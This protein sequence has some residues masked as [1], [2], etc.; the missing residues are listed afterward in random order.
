MP[1]QFVGLVFTDIVESTAR[2]ERLGPEAADA[3]RRAHF[4][5]LRGAIDQHGGREVKNLGDGLMVAFASVTDAVAGA[6]ALQQA[7]ELAGRADGDPVRIR[8]GLSSGDVDE[9]DGDY[10][11]GPVVEAARLCAAADSGQILATEVVRLL[12]GGRG[13]HVFEP[14]GA[15]ELK[16][17]DAPVEACSVHWD[18]LAGEAVSGVPLPSRLVGEATLGV[19][20]RT[21]ERDALGAAW[22]ATLSGTPRT[23][24]LSGEAGI[25]KTRLAGEFAAACHEEGAIVVYGRCEEDLRAAYQP[26]AQALDHLVAHA[27]DDVLARH[28]GRKGGELLRLVPD[29]RQRIP[30]LPDPD[31]ARDPE[32]ERYRFLGAVNDLLA[33]AGS[34]AP[35]L[36]V[37]D[38]LHWADASTLL[39]LR[40]VVTQGG[41]DRVLV[42]G[43][44][45]DTDLSAEHPLTGL[46]ADLHRV[47]GVE[48]I[49]L[50]GLSDHD[51]VEL[52]ESVAGQAMDAE[53]VGLAHLIRSET[54]GN[55]FFVI[56]LLRHLVETDAIYQQDGG[57]WVL[58]SELADLGLP[59]S[60]REVVGR[61]VARLGEEATSVLSLAAVIG[62]DFDLDLLAA[63]AD[64]DEDRLLDL[65]D[66]AMA[67]NVVSEVAGGRFTF[68]HALIEHTLYGDLSAT[69]RQRAHRRIGEALEGLAGDDSDGRVAELAYHWGEATR[70]ADA[71][72]A[73]EYAR[74]AAREA[75]VRLAPDD[76]MRWYRRALDLHEQRGHR[77]N[78]ME[79]CELLIDLGDA[80]RQAGQFEH[81]RTLLDAAAL[82][83]E[84][85]RPELLARAVLA[86]HK[87]TS[88]DSGEL[89]EE[90]IVVAERA[91]E[92]FRTPSAE[93]ALLLATL[94]GLLVLT[95]RSA[96]SAVLVADAVATARSLG[97][98][99]LLLRVLNRTTHITRDEP[100]VDEA[101]R[102]AETSDDPTERF[103]AAW[104][105]VPVELVRADAVAAEEHLETCRTILQ[106]ARRP[107]LEF[108]VAI[109]ATAL[110][111]IRADFDK[112]VPELAALLEMGSALGMPDIV[113]IWGGLTVEIRREQGQLD[114]FVDV[115]T[116]A[117]ADIPSVVLH[118][119][120]GMVNV[121][122][123]RIDEARTSFAALGP[124]VLESI[125]RDQ[126]WASSVGIASQIIAAIADD[127]RAE[128]LLA[129][130]EDEPDI[131]C[132]TG[133]TI[134][135][136][137][138]LIR[139]RALTVL[140]HRD[141]AD[142]EFAAAV[143]IHERLGAPYYVAVSAFEWGEML[144]A[145]ARDGDAER[146][147]ELFERS[148]GLAD[149]HGFA[150][151]QRRIRTALGAG[152]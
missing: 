18:P 149:E 128:R 111:V 132:F 104:N 73:I 122:L 145:R 86:N 123:D 131:I 115:F 95:G 147:R 45:R 67:A 108:L 14:V 5:A 92:Q 71:D 118:L 74:L 21:A 48:R 78:A 55:P 43:T 152:G 93:R 8:V 85:E 146:A 139:A 101:L 41:A 94:A 58:R 107:D 60:V 90:R 88:G 64:V 4:E 137:I 28:V 52:M 62:R 79:R 47:D 138:S 22:K 36:V 24:L 82:A 103:F 140:G 75:M 13:N 34:E 17:L 51:L 144:V 20:G 56:E 76:A 112:A 126:L 23:L 136:S 120:L 119:A 44:Y 97:E 150:T 143:A 19:F 50:A 151:L 9:E 38:D 37:L 49:P 121:E 66:E 3:D 125:P 12:A 91:L 100:A 32:T 53:G 29:L 2:A 68:D 1:T 83:D 39:L 130:V 15:L 40:H 109:Y 106:E 81:R 65:L 25:G 133:G 124:D 31:L 99:G 77:S 72:K 127:D 80:Q 16:G 84:L 113:G 54:D 129:L 142:G 89:D 102:L 6:V 105:A 87:G 110:S 70:P 42:L 57:R 135:G 116:D 59:Q 61:R 117:A 98:D 134:V 33:A 26:W 35:L 27:P 10:F 69:R 63:V 30:E 46:L 114:E 11:G 96:E 7:A 141:E 148:A